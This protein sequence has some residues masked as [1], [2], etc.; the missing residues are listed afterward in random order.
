VDTT[1]TNLLVSQALWR[2]LRARK[3]LMVVIVFAAATTALLVSYILTPIYQAQATLIPAE[4]AGRFGGLQNLGELGG[5][6]SLAG[7][8]VGTSNSQTTESIAVLKSREFAMTFIR[9]ENLLPILFARKWDNNRGAWKVSGADIPTENDAYKYFDR[10]I[11]IVSED[12]KTGLITLTI[13]WRDRRAAAFWAAELITRLNKQMRERAIAESDTSIALLKEQLASANIVP[14]QQS[15]ATLVEAQV[16][17]RTFALVRP[18][19][20][21]RVIDP[22][23]VPDAKAKIFPKRT[24]FLVLGFLAGLMLAISTALLIVLLSGE[25]TIAVDQSRGR[26]R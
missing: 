25:R 1:D 20:A 26:I 3:I 18:D 15:I 19:Y 23:I 13:E 8:N 21:F 4:A 24:L 22:P 9:E 6:A 11:R 7:L 14:L 16:K 12:K 17:R 5:L 2:V 10:E